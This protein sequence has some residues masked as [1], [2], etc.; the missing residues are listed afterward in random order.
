MKDDNGDE[1][2]NVG[3]DACARGEQKEKTRDDRGFEDEKEKAECS[4]RK[5]V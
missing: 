4:L 1:N 2:E 5:S 3:T